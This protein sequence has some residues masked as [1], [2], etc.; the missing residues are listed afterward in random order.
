MA[1]PQPFSRRFR[2][3]TL[4]EFDT[5]TAVRSF[6]VV[7]DPLG[8]DLPPRLEQIPEPVHAQAFVPQLAVKTL[9][10]PVLHR[11][12]RLEVH[13]IDLPLDAPRQKI[14][15]G[16]FRPVV[17][18]NPLRHAA[19][20]DEG[21]HTEAQMIGALKQLEAGRKAEDVAREVGGIGRPG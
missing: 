6:P 2:A 17:A 19:L 16:Q 3:R 21:R 14:T 9:Y 20:G 1:K 8:G 11:R 15:A 4:P 5:Q 12:A 18:T 13:Q 7:L 10:L